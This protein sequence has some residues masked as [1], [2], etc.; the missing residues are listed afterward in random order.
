M[1]VLQNLFKNK[2]VKIFGQV[3]FLN[4]PKI[5]HY[6]SPRDLYK[7]QIWSGIIKKKILTNQGLLGSMSSFKRSI[8]YL[9]RTSFSSESPLKYLL[10]NPQFFGWELLLRYTLPFLKRMSF[11][12]LK[13]YV[14]IRRFFK[15]RIYKLMTLNKKIFGREILPKKFPVFDSSKKILKIHLYLVPQKIS[16]NHWNRK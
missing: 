14:I 5:I 10:N 12:S 13:I 1:D 6:F 7:F 15:K 16:K 3:V 4:F 11:N 9:L 2:W 8:K